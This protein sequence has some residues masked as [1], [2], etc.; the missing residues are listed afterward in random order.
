MPKTKEI[1]L[2]LEAKSSHAGLAESSVFYHPPTFG[3]HDKLWAEGEEMAPER[4]FC[5][6][7]V[8]AKILSALPLTA[9]LAEASH[10]PAWQLCTE[11]YPGAPDGLLLPESAA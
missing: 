9:K 1:P 10:H 5:R 4:T 7:Q 2:S 11:R 3:S 6:G 8:R